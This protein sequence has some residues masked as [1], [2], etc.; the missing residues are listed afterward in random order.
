MVGRQRRQH[1]RAAARF[2]IWL[3]CPRTGNI[4]QGHTA[5]VSMGG[6]LLFTANDSDLA[7][8]VDVEVTFG[9][10]SQDRGGYDLHEA[11]SGAVVVRVERHGYGTGIA[12][13]FGEPSISRCHAEPLLA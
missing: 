6:M 12:V 3:R 4:L 10:W 7:L 2:P 8:G 13:K 9:I 1:E 11:P 5:N